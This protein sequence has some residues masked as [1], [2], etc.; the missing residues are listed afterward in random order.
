MQVNMLESGTW[1]FT[2]DMYHV[3]EN[4][5]DNQPQGWLARDHDE[6]VRSHQMIKTLARRTSAKVVLGH[7]KEV[8]FRNLA[9]ERMKSCSVNVATTDFLELPATRRKFPQ[10]EL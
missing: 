4:Y 6:W 10:L 9:L 3:R 5:E 2:T 1:I 7:D 8:S